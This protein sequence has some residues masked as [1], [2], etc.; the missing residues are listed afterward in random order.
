M[1]LI[2]K[3]LSSQIE[4]NNDINELSTACFFVNLFVKSNFWLQMVIMIK[5]ERV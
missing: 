4:C 5:L 2:Y 1:Y 3:L